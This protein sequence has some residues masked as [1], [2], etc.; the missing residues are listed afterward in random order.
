[1]LI[2]NIHLK[3]NPNYFSFP[4]KIVINLITAKLILK[5]LGVVVL[6]CIN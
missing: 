2:K 3:S 6:V 5:S 4:L 1:M